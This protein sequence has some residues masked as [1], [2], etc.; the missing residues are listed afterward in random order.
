MA[1]RVI[2]NPAIVIPAAAIR[3]GVTLAAAISAIGVMM[4]MN[5]PTPRRTA[6]LTAVPRATAAI[7]PP[8]I[9]G[10]ELL[11]PGR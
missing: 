9:T 3:E 10:R 6:G 1:G 5:L 7:L 2:R 11:K 8:G 4:I